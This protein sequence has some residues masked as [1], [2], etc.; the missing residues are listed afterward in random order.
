MHFEVRQ[1]CPAGLLLFKLTL[2]RGA[3]GPDSVDGKSGVMPKFSGTL[4][5]TEFGMVSSVL[6]FSFSEAVETGG[7]EWAFV[8]T[9]VVK[10]AEGVVVP[11][12]DKGNVVVI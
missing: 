8:A 1:C 7:V 5:S 9:V 12:A 2:A 3:D 11:G 6:Q 10:K 4:S